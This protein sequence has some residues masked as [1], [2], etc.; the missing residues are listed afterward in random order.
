[1]DKRGAA[2]AALRETDRRGAARGH[3]QTSQTD[4]ASIV[5]VIDLSPEAKP[6]EP[7]P[8][9]PDWPAGVRGPAVI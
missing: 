4:I 9:P 1:M 3:Y 5:V 8:G 2:V 7:N 6:T